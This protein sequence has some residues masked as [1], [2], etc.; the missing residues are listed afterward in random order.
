MEP[1][2]LPRSQTGNGLAYAILIHRIFP[3]RT[4]GDV[5]EGRR[6]RPGAKLQDA[7]LGPAAGLPEPPLLLEYAGSDRKGHGHRRSQHLYILWRYNRDSRDWTQLA[8]ASAEGLEWVDTLRRVALRNLSGAVAPAVAA[9]GAT[10][11]ILTALESELEVLDTDSRHLLL[12]MLY[13]QFTARLVR[14]GVPETG[15]R[16]GAR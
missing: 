12:G 13:E 10:S 14:D 4:M 9:H 5:F 2:R 11:R 6:L 15:R 1:I 8:S 16:Q 3:H 7:E